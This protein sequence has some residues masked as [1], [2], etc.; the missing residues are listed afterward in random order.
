M[1]TIDTAGIAGLLGVTRPY[2]TD[3]LVK[4]A[5]FP[6]PVVNRSRRMRRWL[7]SDVQTWASTPKEPS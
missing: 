7:V 1:S 5:G 2:V 4:Q 6:T 3:V